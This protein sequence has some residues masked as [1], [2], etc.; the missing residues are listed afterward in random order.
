[1]DE[2][3]PTEAA[4]EGL[5]LT[6][7]RPRAVLWWWGGYLVTGILQVAMTLT[8]PMKRV[9]DLQPQ[10]AEAWSTLLRDPSNKVASAHLSA[11]TGDVEGWA[12]L[13]I[14]VVVLCQLV[15]STAI[16]RAVVRPMESAFGYLRLS[17]D[18]L[19]QLGLALLAFVAF[20]AYAF[21]VSLVTGILVAVL[22]LIV[23]PVLL[24]GL[25]FA[26]IVIAFLYPAVRLSLAPAMT[27]A[28]GRISFMRSWPLT[29]GRFWPLFGGYLI[30]FVLSAA[31]W[32]SALI[33][34]AI[35]VTLALHGSLPQLTQMQ[36]LIQPGVLAIVVINS[37]F[38]AL[39][40]TTVTAPLASAFRQLAGRTEAK[41]SG[42]MTDS[43]SNS[44]WGRP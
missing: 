43:P 34:L 1:M 37:L 29:R 20:L 6:R 21:F 28:E 2:F 11:L 9:A 15:L 33:I 22:S 32:A 38:A 7:E 27:L 23:P 16:L 36:D 19:R 4:L 42:P 17:I 26:I 10:V 24:G 41:P 8:P 44:P 5:R 31:L 12:L 14:A 25:V 40:G 13:F 39:I 3:S 30:A 35:F 18:E